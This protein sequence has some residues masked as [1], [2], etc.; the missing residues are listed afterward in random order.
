MSTNDPALPRDKKDLLERI[1]NEWL[2]LMRTI[3][4]LT[5]EQLSAPLAGGWSAKDNLAHLATWERFLAHYHLQGKPP[6]EILDLDAEFFDRLDE[7]GINA[8]IYERNRLRSAAD[9]LDDLK[10]SHALVLDLLDKM[11]FEN[12]MLPHFPDDPE[13]RPLVGWVIG[14]TYDHYREHRQNIERKI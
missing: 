12:L 2:A 13:E 9:I 8:I 10:R 4:G 1:E 11:S 6:H 14:N 7:N 5:L 3:E